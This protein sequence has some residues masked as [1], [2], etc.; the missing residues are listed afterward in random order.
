MLTLSSNSNNNI[1]TNNRNTISRVSLDNNSDYSSIEQDRFNNPNE[2]IIGQE[3][4][5]KE[6]GPYFII[7]FYPNKCCSILA[8]ILNLIP[9]GLG[10]ML[11]GINRNSIKY[12]IGGIIQ[13][14]LIDGLA[15]IGGFLL[16]KKE[17]FKKDYKKILP[18]FLFVTST[19][20]YLVSIYIGVINNFIFI[21]TKRLKKYHAKEFGLFILLLN[22][23]IPGS[24]TLM[25]QSIVPNKCV[26]KMKRT[27]NGML[28]LVM[29]IILF[30]YFCGLEKMN[31]NLLLFIFLAVVEYLYVIGIS[32][33]FLRN[34]II[35]DN[36]VNEIEINDDLF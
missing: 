24:G 9:G 7:K 4:S 5:Y 6:N 29:F 11:L 36:I 12:I 22:L 19:L 21:N 15:I 18:I 8:L 33:C 1:N 20:F 35:S 3:S 13:F 2:E 26:I 10:T 25:I 32:I 23:I 31:D 34:I 28:Q 14:L 17:W 16:K 30:L 27:L